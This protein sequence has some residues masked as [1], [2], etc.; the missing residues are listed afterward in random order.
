[1][2]GF[3][4]NPDLWFF[5]GF[6]YEK[7]G[8]IRDPDWL[9]DWAADEEEGFILTGMETLQRA[10][11]EICADERQPLAV[12][13]AGELAEHLVNARYMELIAKA[14]ARAKSALKALRGLPVF[15]TAHD[16]DTVHRTL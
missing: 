14:H 11:A 3:E 6:A 15:A 1:M 12:Q 2:N 9:S 10:F 4:T 13:L 16:W 7:E 5:N 8:D